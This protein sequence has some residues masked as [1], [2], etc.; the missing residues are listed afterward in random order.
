MWQFLISIDWLSAIEAIATILTLYVAYSALHT[1]KHQ[2][3]AQKQTDF[4]DGLT[5]KV[6]E[7]I[8]A[9]SQP[10]YFLRTIHIR[11]E[12]HKHFNVEADQ[13]P[14][15][16]IIKYIELHGKEDSDALL[17]HMTNSNDLFA[18]INSLTARGQVYKFKNYTACRDAINMLLWQHNRLQA[19]AA[20]IGSQNMNWD[21]PEVMKSIE[22]ML[23]V[24]PD[25]VDQYIT[26][27]NLKFIGFVNENYTEIYAGT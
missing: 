12:S 21:N 16:H 24:D 5:D 27:S 4:L 13:K 11:F 15:S 10:I 6:H 7:Y 1:W 26:Q 2:S 25:S 9:L 14:H 20:V 23:T 19:V 8:Q 22:N 17:K 3:K 18:Q